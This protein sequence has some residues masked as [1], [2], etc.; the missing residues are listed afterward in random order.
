MQGQFVK[1]IRLQKE[2][3]DRDGYYLGYSAEIG[4]YVLSV[5]VQWETAVY[6]RYYRMDEEDFLGYQ[7]NREG[8]LRKYAREIGQND[9]CFTE[10]FLG[11]AA[12]RD[13][14]GAVGFQNLFPADGNPFQGYL[15][16][17]D[18]LYARIV[19]RG[20]EVFVPPVRLLP[21]GKTDAERRP[22]RQKCRLM[23]NQNSEP[24]C[25]F[26]DNRENV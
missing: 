4:L 2:I 20:R 1:T 6:E 8:F 12:L 3:R 18:A 25:F 24:V 17:E 16:H 21:D 11:S 23:M 19:W 26:L 5:M 10:R 9:D 22:L 7:M 14:D 15:F 13:Y